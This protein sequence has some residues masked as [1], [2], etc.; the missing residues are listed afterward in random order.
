MPEVWW[1]KPAD[2]HLFTDKAHEDAQLLIDLTGDF[3]M[4]MA[5]E[6][7]V[8]TLEHMVTKNEY[9]VDNVSILA[10]LM[11]MVLVCEVLPGES[12]TGTDHCPVDTILN[13]STNL[14]EECCTRNFRLVDW[15]AFNKELTACLSFAE[16]PDHLRMAQDIDQAVN[17]LTCL[18]QGIITDT[19][20]ESSTA[21]FNHRWWNAE[22]ESLHTQHTRA[23]HVSHK[24]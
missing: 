13:L 21:P 7:G 23:K 2:H 17:V 11:D 10:D 15:K 5:L 8:P 6:P 20:K 3:N 18:L 9:Q 19:I 1:D 22:L 16:I 24:L 4:E 12:P 14:A